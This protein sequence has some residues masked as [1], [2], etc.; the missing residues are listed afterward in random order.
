MIPHWLRGEIWHVSKNRFHL[1]FISAT[2]SH[3][4]GG[5]ES[6]IVCCQLIR[7]WVQAGNNEVF[8]CCVFEVESEIQEYVPRFLYST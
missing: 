2:S 8:Q 1:R 5:E 6:L 4:K 7:F 3:R